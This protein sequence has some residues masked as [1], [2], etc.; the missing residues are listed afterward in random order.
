MRKNRVTSDVSEILPMLRDRFG[1][2]WI[3]SRNYQTDE[4]MRSQNVEG[5]VSP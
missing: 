2:Q 4:P 1:Y 3:V 5:K